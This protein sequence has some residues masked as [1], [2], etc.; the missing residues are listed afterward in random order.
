MI[1]GKLIGNPVDH[2]SV[3]LDKRLEGGCVSFGGA[4]DQVRIRRHHA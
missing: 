3:T 1:A 2:C 4:G